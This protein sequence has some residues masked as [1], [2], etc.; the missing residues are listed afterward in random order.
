MKKDA[1]T[2]KQELRELKLKHEALK[3]EFNEL[4]RDYDKV[5]DERLR[6][7]RQLRLICERVDYSR[8][9]LEGVCELKPNK[10]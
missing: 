9:E 5:I 8:L 2:L 10:S 3:K 7:Y 4:L 6:M 1:D